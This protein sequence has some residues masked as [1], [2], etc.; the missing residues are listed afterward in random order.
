MRDVKAV[1][2]DAALDKV[3]ITAARPEAQ[4]TADQATLRQLGAAALLHLRRFSEAAD[5]I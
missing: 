2:L 1:R 5:N 4:T 3:T